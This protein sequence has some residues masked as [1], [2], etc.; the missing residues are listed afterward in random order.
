MNKPSFVISC[1][2]DTYSG[3]GA[4][5]RDI[6][7]AIIN[8]GRYDVKILPQRWGD[9][10]GNFLQDNKEWDFL[11][12]F[13][14]PQLTAQPDIW[15]QI[16]I[17]S[18][19]SPQGKYNIGC[20]AGIESTGCDP[21]WID[22]LNRMDVNWVSSNHSKKVFSEINFE[23]RD[24]TTN[25]PLGVTKL[26]KPIEVVFEGID[27]D[28]YKHVPNEDITLNLDAIKESFCYL[29]VGHWMQGALGH[30]RKNV[31][32]T[33]KYFFDAFKNQKSAPALILKVSTGRNSYM[34]REAILDRIN[35]I[36]STYKNDTLPNVYILNGGLSDIEMNELYNH[37]KVKAMV[38]FTKGEG[39]GRPLA[40][41]GLSKKPIIA[42]GW[43]GHL[44]FLNPQN[45]VL[46]PGY[47]EN[48]DSSAAN[49]WLRKDTQWFQI[50]EKFAVSIYKDVYKNYKKFAEMGKKQ[51]FYVKTNFSYEKMAELVDKL[52][53][54]TIPEFPKHVE[55]V[56]PTLTTPKL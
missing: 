37:P 27:L 39:Y 55:L 43:S 53:L 56:L 54:N 47:L 14:T 30:D 34:S 40:E 45:T 28:I 36:K 5:A 2:I 24:K 29:F 10:P 41:F 1:P 44:D 25:Q 17:P 33:I 13:I 4:R 35:I 21:S 19:F 8:T 16:T 32:L 26:E 18:E 49:Q 38:S 9:T 11:I 23:K 31:G 48:V 15:M 6:V 46:L 7:K 12:P 50:S 22:G 52:L 3:Y 20:T 42:S 51:G